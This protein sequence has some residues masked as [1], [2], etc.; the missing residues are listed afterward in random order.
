MR[1][2]APLPSLYSPRLPLLICGPRGWRWGP[3]CKQYVNLMWQFVIPFMFDPDRATL[4][5]KIAF[6]FF[7]LC[8]FCIIYLWWYQLVTAGR[9]YQ[10]LDE[11]FA[12]GVP[13]RKFKG[14]KTDVQMQNEAAMQ[15]NEL[16]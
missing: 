15:D 14:Y 12:K 9:S 2:S 5:A 7:G 16:A 3:R 13:V 4:G 8:F 10:E 11:L 6:I 1:P